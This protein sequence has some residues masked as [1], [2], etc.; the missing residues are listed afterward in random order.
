MRILFSW[1]GFRDLRFIAHQLDEAAFSEALKSEEKSRTGLKEEVFSPIFTAH[2]HLMDNKQPL[3]R[4]VIF[5]DISNK[6]LHDG[7]RNFFKRHIDQVD[8]V[9]VE[10]PSTNVRNYGY[11]LTSAAKQWQL[12]KESIEDR[13]D[14]VPYFSLS[15]GTTAMK[16]F[17]GTVLL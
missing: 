10:V 15:S 14:I 6:T 7:T 9:N 3:D 11:I 13:K 17:C 1:I 12:T 8:I 16:A 5:S 2:N 4:L